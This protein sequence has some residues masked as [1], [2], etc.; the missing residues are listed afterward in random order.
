[1]QF[2]ALPLFIIQVLKFFFDT[3]FSDYSVYIKDFAL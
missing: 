2:I 3:I 1:M